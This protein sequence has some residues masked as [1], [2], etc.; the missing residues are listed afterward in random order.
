MLSWTN[1]GGQTSRRAVVCSMTLSNE[2]S[3][4]NCITFIRLILHLLSLTIIFHHVA[5]IIVVGSLH[6][7][8]LLVLDFCALSLF[9]ACTMTICGLK[10]SCITGSDKVNFIWFNGILWLSGFTLLWVVKYSSCDGVVSGNVTVR[11]WGFPKSG[12]LDPSTATKQLMT[13]WV[14]GFTLLWVVKYS[15]C[16]SVVNRASS[17][18]LYSYILC[19]L[20]YYD[21]TILEL[22]LKLQSVRTYSTDMLCATTSNHIGWSQ[23]YIAIH[24]FSFHVA[25]LCICWSPLSN[26]HSMPADRGKYFHLVDH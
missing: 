24:Y 12:P 11:K 8:H 7:Y 21:H 18:E 26:T 17:V 5:N 25:F 16:D 19:S 10:V 1:H 23:A 4:R 15:S 13:N 22:T 14:S 3:K 20:H 6:N 9:I 2:M